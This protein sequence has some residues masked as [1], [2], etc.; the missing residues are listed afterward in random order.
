M[1]LGSRTTCPVTGA[2][3]YV[4]RFVGVV[5]ICRADDGTTFKV[6][7]SQRTTR[8]QSKDC[9][10]RIEGIDTVFNGKTVPRSA[11]KRAVIVDDDPIWKGCE[12]TSYDATIVR[13]SEVASD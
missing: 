4:T 9:L 11:G 10:I 6:D 2:K 7:K 1:K 12:V 13:L 5:A 8:G 3:G